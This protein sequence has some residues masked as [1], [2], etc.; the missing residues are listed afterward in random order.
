MKS[1][2]LCV[3]NN[4]NDSRRA[5]I[6]RKKKISWPHLKYSSKKAEH[7]TQYR[8]IYTKKINGCLYYQPVGRGAL[9][10]RKINVRQ[11]KIDLQDEKQ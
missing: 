10:G 1:G 6:Y 4:A 9:R 7:L 2:L 5:I 3:R 8:R 11:H